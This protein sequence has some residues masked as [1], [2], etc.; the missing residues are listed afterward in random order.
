MSTPMTGGEE[1]PSGAQRPTPD[2]ALKML[3]EGNARYQDP[4][5][6]P[7]DYSATALLATKHEP[8]AGILGCGDARVAAELIFDRGPGD[9][10]MVRVAGNFLSDY[11]LASMEFAVEFL[12]VPLLM[13]LGHTH[14]GAV[15]SAVRVVQDGID[16]PGRL[17]VLIDAIEPSVLQVRMNKP[18]C[19]PDE[20]LIG[21][22]EANVRRQVRRLSTISPLISAARD[23]GKVKVVGAIFELETGSV[24]ILD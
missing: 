21:A 12:N 1:S 7:E 22:I 13:V 20:L 6:P 10:F 15:T 5:V 17:P 18:D 4:A 11:G 16:L 19:S 9:L 24:R 3:L 23:A 14:C 8:I 2:E